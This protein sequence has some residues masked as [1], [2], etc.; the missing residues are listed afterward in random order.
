VK[1]LTNY[2]VIGIILCSHTVVTHSS[3]VVRCPVF[4]M[5][6]LL[7]LLWV[8]IFDMYSGAV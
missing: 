5:L 2:F 4:Y 1:G 6:L 7:L 3:M 8:L